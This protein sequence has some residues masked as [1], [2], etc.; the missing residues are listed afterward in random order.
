ME[1]LV[2]HLESIFQLA[3]KEKNGKLSYGEFREVLKWLDMDVSQFELEV[4]LS[5]SDA[6]GD[7]SIDFSEFI[8]IIAELL[9]VLLVC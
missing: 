8:P 9:Q 6:N 7:G 4:L 2:H 1:T 3:D 5:E